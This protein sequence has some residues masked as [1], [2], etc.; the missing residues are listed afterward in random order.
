ML[1]WLFIAGEERK[2]PTRGF[3]I[4]PARDRRMAWVQV[5]STALFHS[6]THL[7]LKQYLLLAAC[8]TG[9]VILVQF[10]IITIGEWMGD[11]FIIAISQ[12]LHTHESITLRANIM[13]LEADIR[14]ICLPKF[15]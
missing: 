6:C 7:F 15:Q 13:W 9:N 4:Q 11:I 2:H 12:D 10:I 5:V 14:L 8:R 3:S 1:N